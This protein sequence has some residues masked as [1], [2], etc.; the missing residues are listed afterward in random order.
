MKIGIDASRYNEQFATGVELYSREIIDGI[1]REYEGNSVTAGQAG[2]VEIVLY[3]RAKLG[4]Q[5]NYKNRVI[6]A[7]RFWTL[8]RLSLEMLFHKPDVL[9]VPSHV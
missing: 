8:G 3:S 7:K 6:P 9:F 4:V 5:G 1:V 2:R